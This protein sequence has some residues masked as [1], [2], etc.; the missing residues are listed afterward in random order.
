[1][2]HCLSCFLLPHVWVLIFKVQDRQ[3]TYF[4]AWHLGEWFWQL[5]CVFQLLRH[6]S[7]NLVLITNS[8]CKEVCI[9]YAL[10]FGFFFQLDGITR[11]QINC[12]WLFL[13]YTRDLVRCNLATDLFPLSRV[14]R[15]R[16][17]W[18]N[19]SFLVVTQISAGDEISSPLGTEREPQLHFPL[20][21]RRHVPMRGFQACQQPCNAWAVAADVPMSGG[22]RRGLLPRSG[23]T[24]VS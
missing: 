6:C 21:V 14:L 7:L 2:L 16:W 20:L 18:D 5:R 3:T 1:M 9:H 19:S 12:R 11:E 23:F 24:L 15:R 22:E 17:C 8:F 4:L 10:C 13:F